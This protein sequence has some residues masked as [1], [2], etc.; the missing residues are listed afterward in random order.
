MIERFVRYTPHEITQEGQAGDVYWYQLQ[1]RD[2]ADLWIALDPA[3][4]Q[5]VF[6]PY[7]EDLATLFAHVGG[8]DQPTVLWRFDYVSQ[9]PPQVTYRGH[10]GIHERDP[11]EGSLDPAIPEP[12]AVLFDVLELDIA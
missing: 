2:A 1:A 12:I 8:L 7:H 10:R 3:N 4:L 5:F 11:S 6:L 9:R